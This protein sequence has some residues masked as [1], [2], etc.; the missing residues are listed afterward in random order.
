MGSFARVYQ[1][2]MIRLR[3]IAVAA[4][5]LAMAGSAS[6]SLAQGCVS[7]RE[8]RALLEEGRIIPF[9][10]ALR[11]A[12]YGSDQLAGDPELCQAGGG[13]VYQ[14]RV[15]RDGQVSSVSIPAN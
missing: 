11:R 15:V 13:F 10:E 14:V 6:P 7:G 2:G 8:G 4:L 9:P 1:G 3:I 12:G 5:V